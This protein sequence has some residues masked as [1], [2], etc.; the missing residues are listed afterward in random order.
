MPNPGS[1][2]AMD[3]GCK[4]AV[5]DNGHGQGSGWKNDDGSPVF[6]INVE[7]PIHG[8]YKVAMYK[9]SKCGFATLDHTE[10]DKHIEEH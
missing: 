3:M 5:L 10:L 9:C 1:Q 2:E 4:C 6:W 7:C 8:T